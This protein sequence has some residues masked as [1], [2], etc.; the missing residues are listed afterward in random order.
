MFTV[1]QIKILHLMLLE[2]TQRPVQPEDWGTT[3]SGIQLHP[4]I[5]TVDLAVENAIYTHS[6]LHPVP[7][8]PQQ[9]N[10]PT[11]GPA[12]PSVQAMISPSSASVVME[13]DFKTGEHFPHGGNPIAY[14]NPIAHQNPIARQ[15]PLAHQIPTARQDPLT[16]QNLI[17]HQHNG[18][19]H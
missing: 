10:T 6:S 15:D 3:A 11:T 4:S 19:L 12:A 17:A 1:R 2:S 13:L 5:G 8:P 9:A 14:Q 16:H 7:H 18:V